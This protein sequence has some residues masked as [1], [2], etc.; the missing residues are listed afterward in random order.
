[1]VAQSHSPNTW[2]AEVKELH[3]VPCYLG[4]YDE[5]KA[6]QGYILISKMPSQ[7]NK[8]SK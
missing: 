7:E 5:L 3:Q 4:L 2:E 1:M 6:S 8:N